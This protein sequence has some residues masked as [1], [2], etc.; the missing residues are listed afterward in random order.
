MPGSLFARAALLPEGWARDVLLEWNAAGELTRVAPGSP[1]AA[2]PHAP[3]PVLP[4]MPNVHSHAFQRAMAGLAEVRGHPT[5]DFWT[6]REAM[7]RTVLA[8]RPED[9]ESVAFQLYVE[10]LEHG[11]TSVAEFHYLHH[12]PAG[13]PYA[14]RTELARRIISAARRAGIAL[15]FLP[16]VYTHGGLGHRPL[17]AA[18]KRFAGDAHSIA[19]LLRQLVAEH[20]GSAGLRFG[21]APHSV[22]AVDAQVLIEAI[23]ALQSIDATAPVHIHASEQAGEVRDCLAT[24]GATPIDWIMDLVPV[25]RRWCFIHATHA[26]AVELERMRL[27]QAV[28]GLCP[29]T[30]AN[31]GDGIFPFDP[32]SRAGGRWGI[33]GDSHVSVSPLEELRAL[34][35]SQRLGLR[36]RNVAATEARPQV[37]TNLWADACAGGAQA[38]AQAC[39]ALAPGRRADFV[40]LDGD[41]PDFEGLGPEAMLA[42]A[43]F[44]GGIRR[45]RETYAGGLCVVKDGRHGRRDD[46][47]RSYRAALGRLRAGS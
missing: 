12:D 41:D 10:M 21:I 40:A 4:G 3:G 16:V 5:D 33:G 36:V 23:A 34:E 45:V 30:E 38:L 35:L 24:H 26:T 19:E 42:V 8:L 44:S 32:Y 11:Y 20:A 1:H 18:Q 2:A 15:T 17:N 6:W 39:G 43:M 7:Y 27:A 46:A 9:V 29:T 37:A 31:L 28:A 25:D 22:R 47:A 13:R 14:D